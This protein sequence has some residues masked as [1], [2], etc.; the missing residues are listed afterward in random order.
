M[1][2]GRVNEATKCRM[3]PTMLKGHAMISFKRLA[4]ESIGSFVELRKLSSN[5][6]YVP[7][8]SGLIRYEMG[9]EETR[10]R[11]SKEVDLVLMGGN[12][13]MQS[14]HFVAVRL[15]DQTGTILGFVV[16]LGQLTIY[17]AL[18]AT[19]GFLEV[20]CGC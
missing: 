8:A 9:K 6:G 4:L 15:N 18:M 14:H 19:I 7:P 17:L 10:G 2:G 20:S 13:K 5:D 12:L 11:R 16:Y 3:F 1:E